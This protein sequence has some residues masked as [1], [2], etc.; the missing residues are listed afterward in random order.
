MPVGWDCGVTAALITSTL[1]LDENTCLMKH[2]CWGV[3]EPVTRFRDARSLKTNS[4]HCNVSQQSSPQFVAA[5]VSRSLALQL[6]PPCRTWHAVGKSTD[7]V[8]AQRQLT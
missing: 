3:L 5:G 2:R 8:Y 6:V 1:L 4:S 7:L